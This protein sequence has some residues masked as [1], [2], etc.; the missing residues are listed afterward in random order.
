MSNDDRE[1]GGAEGAYRDRYDEGF[2]M[3]GWTEEGLAHVAAD[4][5]SAAL[6][7]HGIMIRSVVA[8]GLNVNV[9]F[10]AL[11]DAET[12]MT[13]SIDS[14]G[15][16]G[17]RYDRATSGCITLSTLDPNGD[18]PLNQTEAAFRLG[19]EWRIHPDMRGRRMGWHATVTMPHTDA[20]SVTATLNA[21]RNLGGAA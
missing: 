9:A 6:N 2:T 10:G 21:L 18:V 16:P 7:A 12:M 4:E 3:T 13:L 14:S 1:C 11:R 15:G 17:S 8:E 20:N 19:W 5:L